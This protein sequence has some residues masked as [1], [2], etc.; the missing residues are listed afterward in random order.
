MEISMK[1]QLIKFLQDTIKRTGGDPNFS[2]TD[3]LFVS[4]KF[5]SLDF[6][7]LLLF[8]EEH[9]KIP[10]SQV[11]DDMSKIDNVNKIIEYIETNIRK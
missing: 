3:S 2:D 6:V 5:D 10:T 8:I 4:Q 7:D 11:G 1:E 9:Y